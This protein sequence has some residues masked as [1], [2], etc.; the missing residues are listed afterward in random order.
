MYMYVMQLNIDS[1]KESKKL[2]METEV[3][4]ILTCFFNGTCTSY[5]HCTCTFQFCD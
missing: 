2:K 5:I 3:M 1:Q 4:D